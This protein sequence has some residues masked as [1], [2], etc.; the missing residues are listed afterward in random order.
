MK[1]FGWLLGFM[2]VTQA[3]A[4]TPPV[5]EPTTAPIAVTATCAI[6]GT[7]VGRRYEGKIIDNTKPGGK[8]WRTAMLSIPPAELEH[9][10]TQEMD[11]LK[12]DMPRY[13]VA[14]MAAPKDV[15]L[16]TLEERS[17]RAWTGY[18]SGKAD[19]EDDHSYSF[20]MM[21]DVTASPP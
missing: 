12:A 9:W 17:E 20:Q 6:V 14:R 11:A 7:N 21:C 13:G 18:G 1:Q 3:H 19:S 16:G 4:A 10:I 5:G 2:L 8:P 15:F